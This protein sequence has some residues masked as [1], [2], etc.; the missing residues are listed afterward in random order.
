MAPKYLENGLVSQKLLFMHFGVLLLE[1]L[2]GKEA[3]TF[4][5]ENS[6]HIS[7]ALLGGGNE[8]KEKLKDFVDPPLENNYPLVLAVFMVRLVESC[9][10][11]DPT[12]RP[13]M[14]DVVQSLSRA[15]TTS[16]NWEISNMS[17]YRSY[18]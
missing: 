4:C 9:L 13:I 17:G 2:G 1:I 16:L 18:S 6:M 5:G 11:K 7:E 14:D 15:L 3:T 8:E 10:S 12:H